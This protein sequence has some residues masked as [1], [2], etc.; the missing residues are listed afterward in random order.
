MMFLGKLCT[1]TYE[2]QSHRMKGGHAG[3]LRR[4]AMVEYARLAERVFEARVS[5]A[6]MLK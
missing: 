2:N 1:S 6:H 3:A 4:L 5:S